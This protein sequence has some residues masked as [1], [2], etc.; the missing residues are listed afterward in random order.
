MKAVAIVTGVRGI[1][2]FLA[3]AAAKAGLWQ[4]Q[5]PNSCAMVLGGLILM[6]VCGAATIAARGP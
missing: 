3:G 4:A 6:F 5:D 1:P 2:M